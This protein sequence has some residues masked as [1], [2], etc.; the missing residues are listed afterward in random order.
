MTTN[1]I[2]TE[3]SLCF[4]QLIGIQNFK[5]VYAAVFAELIPA[6]LQLWV[7]GVRPTHPYCSPRDNASLTVS[8]FHQV[9]ATHPS[10]RRRVSNHFGKWFGESRL[11]LGCKGSP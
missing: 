11:S 1:P 3:E 2:S 4:V 10:P 8:S 5:S 9:S 6:L 7:G